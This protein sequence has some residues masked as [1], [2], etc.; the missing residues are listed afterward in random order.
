MRLVQC[1]R[2][3]CR[4]PKTDCVARHIMANNGG[5]VESTEGGRTKHKES[6]AMCKNCNQGRRRAKE[7]G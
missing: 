4:L 2:M 5:S 7:V 1:N 6:L 3:A